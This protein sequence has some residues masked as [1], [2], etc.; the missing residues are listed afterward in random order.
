MRA[1]FLAGKQVHTCTIAAVAV[2]ASKI[3]GSRHGLICFGMFLHVFAFNSDSQTTQ[4]FPT[5]SFT[6]SAFG[7]GAFDTFSGKPKDPA[8][9]RD[10]REL[11]AVQSSIWGRPWPNR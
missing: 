7:Q 10:P 11:G 8:D 1:M 5:C 2:A 6:Q 4:M 9:L 3:V